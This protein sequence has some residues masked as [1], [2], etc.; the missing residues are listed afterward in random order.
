MAQMGNVSGGKEIV[1]FTSSGALHHEK[2][3]WPVT[4]LVM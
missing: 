2:C 1:E 3:Y 4:F